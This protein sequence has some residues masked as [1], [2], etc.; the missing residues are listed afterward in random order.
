M[1]EIV[2][3]EVGEARAGDGGLVG[4]LD[5]R[6]LARPPPREDEPGPLDRRRRVANQNVVDGRTYRNNVRHALPPL[7]TLPA[8]NRDARSRQVDMLPLQPEQLPRRYPVLSASATIVA[9]SPFR[10][11]WHAAEEPGDSEAVRC[12]SRLAPGSGSTM[13]GTVV[14]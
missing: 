6:S 9:S 10:D 14:R 13:S 4:P 5:R 11:C 2:E 3:S 7:G 12:R 8:G 1:P